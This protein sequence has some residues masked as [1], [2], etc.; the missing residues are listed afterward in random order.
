MDS[1]DRHLPTLHTV[2]ALLQRPPAGAKA[3]VVNPAN[4]YIVTSLELTIATVLVVVLGMISDA[5]AT[6]EEGFTETTPNGL[7]IE[8]V[9]IQDG[10][11]MMGS[12]D[13]E[14]GRSSREGP[15]KSVHI[16]A[17]FALGRTE[18]TVRQFAAFVAATGYVTA[19]EKTGEARVLEVKTGRLIANSGINWRHD[20]RG[21]EADENLP[22]IRVTWHDAKAFTTWLAKETGQDYR[23]PSEAEFEYALRAG[24]TTRYWWGDGSPKRRLEN[25]PGDRERLRDLRWPAAFRGYTDGNW[26][27]SPVASFES[28]PFGLFDMGGNITEWTEDCFVGSLSD[29]PADGSP[30]N[31]DNCE[32]RVLKGSA[33]ALPPTLARSA[34]RDGVSLSYASTLAGFRVARSMPPAIEPMAQK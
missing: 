23:L 10:K 6:D 34:S 18:V 31:V 24:S 32:E 20:F 25:L 17:P 7:T 11:F 33:W 21:R 4:S 29:T 1:T 30:H 28:N 14:A 5:Y 19:A 26:G 9:V 22:V 13:N 2:G 27:P 12:P 16:S 15:Q 8:L 3:R